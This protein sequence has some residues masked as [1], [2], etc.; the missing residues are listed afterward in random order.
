VR[1]VFHLK[2]RVWSGFLNSRGFAPTTYQKFAM[3]K[4]NIRK[5]I[6]PQIW[7]GMG[8][9][10]W[11]FHDVCPIVSSMEFPSKCTRDLNIFNVNIF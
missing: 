2:L 8:S 6:I 7:Y 11:H 10:L 4:S 1:L 5:L 9:F 3:L